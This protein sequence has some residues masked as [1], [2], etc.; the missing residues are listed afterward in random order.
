MKRLVVF[1]MVAAMIWSL[2][3]VWSSS[4]EPGTSSRLALQQFG[5]QVAA[6]VSPRKLG[7]SRQPLWWASFEGHLASATTTK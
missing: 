6:D 4:L 3:V 1:G 7:D 2:E 5:N